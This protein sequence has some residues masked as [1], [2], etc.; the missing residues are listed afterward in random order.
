[1]TLFK[2]ESTGFRKAFLA[3]H[4]LWAIGNFANLAEVLFGGRARLPAA[5]FFYSLMPATANEGVSAMIEVYSPLVANQPAALAGREGHRN[6][7][8]NIVVNSSE[9]KEV[10]YANV[11]G[12]DPLPWKIAMWGS[13]IDQRVLA[14]LDKSGFLTIG[15]CEADGALVISQGLEL[16]SIASSVEPIEKHTELAGRMTLTVGAL[17]NRRYLF[18]FPAESLTVISADH[19]GVRRGRYSVPIRVCRPPHVIVGASR[20]FAVYTDDFLVAPGRQIGITSPS[21]N[22]ALLKAMAL[23]LNS[24]FV[25]YHQFLTSTESG[26]Q[27]TRNTLRSLRSIPLPFDAAGVGDWEGL[28]SRIVRESVGRDDF[29]RPEFVKELNDLTF[30]GLK[31][32]SRARAA[33]EDLVRVRLGLN[34]G[35]IEQSAVRQPPKEELEVYAQTLRDELDDFI[36]QSSS[37]RHRI[38]ILVG[39][40]SGLVA[41]DLVAGGGDRAVNVWSASERGALQLAETRRRLIEHRAQWLYFNRNLRIYEGSR[42]YVLKPLQRF[43]WTRT[44]A[45]QDATEIIADC[46]EPEPNISLRTLQ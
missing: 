27:K 22:T 1:M 32:S 4:E 18:R 7:T 44:Q 21:G 28:H 46:L 34:Q 36:S 30:E 9:L 19:T 17:K 15:Q 35:K 41:V 37:T 33:V 16:R 3:R 40:N 25:A 31:L 42:T 38:D 2:Y 10:R 13:P 11:L 12:G 29:D 26:I 5:A 8:W 6:E 39:G 23:Y 24:D 43:H 14:S 45:I 20:N